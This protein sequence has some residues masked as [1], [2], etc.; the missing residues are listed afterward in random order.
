MATIEREPAT[1]AANAVGIAAA[2]TATDIFTLTGS[3]TRTVKVRK[4]IATGIQTTAGQVLV[5]AL[6]RSTANAGATTAQTA[7]PLD[8]N[9]DA[10][11]SA[12]ARTYTA[13]PTTG[14]LVGRVMAIRGLVPAAATAA[15]Q[16]RFVFDFEGKIGKP[17]TLR[18]IAEVLAINLNGVTV[19]GGTFDFSVIWTEE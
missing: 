15:D 13:N 16:E 1:Y 2:A 8:S 11:A 19:T 12:T 18:G 10:A 9:D 7:V 5:I 6:K 17:L 3:A 4:I 14:T